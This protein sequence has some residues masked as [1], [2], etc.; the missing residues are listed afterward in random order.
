[1]YQILKS[2]SNILIPRF[3]T[4]GDILLLSGFLE[5]LRQIYPEAKI[6]LLVREGYD[7]LAKVLP[8]D[9]SWITINING[10]LPFSSYSHDQIEVE[11]AK[12]VSFDW[13]LVCFTT[14]NR[15]WPEVL[16]AAA[17]SDS[18]LL[19]IGKTLTENEV[20]LIELYVGKSLASDDIFDLIVPVPEWSHEIEKYNIFWSKCFSSSERLPLPLLT[21]TETVTNKCSDLL[22]ELAIEGDFFITM[23]AGVQNVPIKTW[24]IE[25]FADI[26]CWIQDVYGWTPLV[27][28][29]DSEEGII[30]QLVKEVNSRGVK[31]KSWLGRKGELDLLA[32]LIANSRLY[33]GNDSAPLHIACAV[34]VPVVGLYGGG[35]FPRFMP[36]GERAVGVAGELPCF[37]CLWSCMFG[38]APCMR[39]VTVEDA[40]RAVH[41]VLA[42]EP[43]GIN[44]LPVLSGCG[45][46]MDEFLQKCLE[47]AKRGTVSN[48]PSLEIPVSSNNATEFTTHEMLDRINALESSL[49]WRITK[50]LRWLGN[51]IR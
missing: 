10:Y 8:A 5:S 50:P 21:I 18:C 12:V 26:I 6:T 30:C 29:Q 45:E 34:R 23:P 35:T 36:V 42:Q 51:I 49:S 11:L 43:P 9:L 17:L 16:I 41:L 24:P 20:F 46:R 40:K 28:G 7:Q 19:A 31:A 2:P 3:D 13:D 1:M 38:D 47:L 22:A 48:C 14:N 25:R 37:G 32:G 33:I 4:L 39:I 44:Y 15:T 27:V